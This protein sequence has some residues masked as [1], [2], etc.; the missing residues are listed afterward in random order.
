MRKGGDEEVRCAEHR[1]GHHAGSSLESPGSERWTRGLDSAVPGED[2]EVS[3]GHDP[4]SHAAPLA[5]LNRRSGK[6]SEGAGET[7]SSLLPI[8]EI[9]AISWLMPNPQINHFPPD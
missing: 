4:M 2:T 8:K 1:Q 5:E 9:W 6:F 3:R 7:A